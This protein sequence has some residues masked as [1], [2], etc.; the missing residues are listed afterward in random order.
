LILTAQASAGS[1]SS[2]RPAVTGDLVASYLSQWLNLFGEQ[3]RASVRFVGYTDE[4]RRITVI[5]MGPK[6]AKRA[7]DVL[8]L[9]RKRILGANKWLKKKYDVTLEDRDLELS[10]FFPKDGGMEELL[11]YRD[12]K[13]GSPGPLPPASPTVGEGNKSDGREK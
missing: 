7:E 8:G 6:D 1:L 10:Y 12:G 4:T 5:V 3:G 9:I 2:T 11:V 13:V